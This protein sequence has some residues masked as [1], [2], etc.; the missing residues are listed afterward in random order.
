[1]DKNLPALSKT[2]NR[3]QIYDWHSLEFA[4]R[5]RLSLAK[6]QLHR[7]IIRRLANKD[8]PKILPRSLIP[9]ALVYLI[10]CDLDHFNFYKRLKRA[11][12]TST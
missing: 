6:L 1:M 7:E 12:E 4:I 11:L 2:G 9:Q 8:R 10:T 3:R 5:T